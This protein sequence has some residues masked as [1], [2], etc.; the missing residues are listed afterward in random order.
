MG[1]RV[2]AA[3][4]LQPGVLLAVGG[5]DGE[6]PPDVPQMLTAHQVDST[7]APSWGAV[8]HAAAADQRR[9]GHEDRSR[10]SIE[11]AARG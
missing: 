2:E 11:F 5:A 4:S 10:V 1:L 7:T 9:E 6:E 8:E 3:Q